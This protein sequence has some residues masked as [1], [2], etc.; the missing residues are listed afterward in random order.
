VAGETR[1]EGSSLAWHRTTVSSPV[2]EIVAKVMVEEG[3]EVEKGDLLAQ[4]AV[5][6]EELEVQRLEQMITK[7]RFVYEATLALHKEKI[8]SKE[9]L[10]EKKSELDQLVIAREVAVADV[11]DRQI[12]APVNGIVVHRLKDPGEAVERVGPIFEIIDVSRLK[13]MFFLP[14][15]HLAKLKKGKE[16]KVH[17]PEFPEVGPRPARLIFI[18]PEV[19]PR[20]GLFRARFEFDNAEAQVRPGVR[21]GLTIPDLE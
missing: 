1:V 7:A 5:R 13:L 3:Q 4:L 20:S 2:E 12:L 21:V 6:K 9:T 17:F 10:L 19:D 14:V 16:Y 8:E 15:K 11:N 18:D